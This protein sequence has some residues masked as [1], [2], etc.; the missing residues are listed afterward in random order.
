MV[1]PGAWLGSELGSKAS[2][3]APATCEARQ[4]SELEKQRARRGSAGD[5]CLR[6]ADAAAQVDRSEGDAGLRLQRRQQPAAQVER[7]SEQ[8]SLGVVPGKLI[9]G[10]SEGAVSE[11]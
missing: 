11:E 4:E 7:E 2:S 9:V 6:G 5:G 1:R 8:P 10:V 3:E